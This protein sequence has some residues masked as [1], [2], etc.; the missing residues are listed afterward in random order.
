MSNNIKNIAL[1]D[2]IC[3]NDAKYI[4]NKL[5]EEMV[6]MDMENGNFISMNNVGADIW[7][8]CEKPMLVKDLV[9]ELIKKYEISEDRCIDETIQF[10]GESMAQ[11]IFTIQNAAD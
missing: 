8:L 6:M 3:R 1:D 5:G 4:A 2:R 9:R 11:N 10:L 7:S